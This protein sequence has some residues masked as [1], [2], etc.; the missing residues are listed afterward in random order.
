MSDE[1]YCKCGHRKSE[2]KIPGQCTGEKIK[3][4]QGAVMLK[5]VSCECIGFVPKVK[6]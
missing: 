2:H 4:E 6:Q 1:E 3:D 5:K